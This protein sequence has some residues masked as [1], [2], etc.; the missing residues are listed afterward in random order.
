[1]Q[2]LDHLLVITCYFTG[3]IHSKLM[4]SWNE[5]GSSWTFD[6][7]GFYRSFI[8]I[9]QFCWS[10][11]LESIYLYTLFTCDFPSSQR[12]SKYRTSYGFKHVNSTTATNQNQMNSAIEYQ[13]TIS[14][15]QDK[16]NEM[17][18]FQHN[19]SKPRELQPVSFSGI[20][21]S[22]LFVQNQ[23]DLAK[24]SIANGPLQLVFILGRGMR[25]SVC[26]PKRCRKLCFRNGRDRW[27][28]C[29]YN[30]KKKSIIQ[31]YIYIVYT[32]YIYIYYTHYIYIYIFPSYVQVSNCSL[33]F[34]VAIAQIT[35]ANQTRQRKKNDQNR[36]W[37]NRQ[38]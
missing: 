1:M 4:S 2:R 16:F 9:W 5:H 32:L 8:S 7:Y 37:D 11:D 6:I 17:L 36:W 23:V 25:C 22:V 28:L 15:T 3:I 26:T 20:Q 24:G 19:K 29:V 31:I 14:Q 12:E 35:P 27:C 18:W 21:R 30:I 10:K 38:L 13:N 33:Y 34:E